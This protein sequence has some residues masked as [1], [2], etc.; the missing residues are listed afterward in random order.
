MAI[1]APQRRPSKKDGGGTPQRSSTFSDFDVEMLRKV[2]QRPPRP[3]MAEVPSE[4]EL[5]S[6]V[7]KMRNGKAGVQSG[8]LPEMVKVA[9]YDEDFLSKL[10]EL[11]KDI[12]EISC[13]PSAWRDSILERISKKAISLCDN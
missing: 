7:G 9:C 1:L 5:M 11:V 12:L 8:I 4:E 2:R 13:V 10:F 3:E 6:A